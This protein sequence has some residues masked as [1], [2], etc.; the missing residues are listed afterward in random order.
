MRKYLVQYFDGKKSKEKWK[1]YR[2]INE[3]CIEEDKIMSLRKNIKWILIE[4]RKTW[5]LLLKNINP[6]WN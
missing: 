6:E 5:R 1:E 3:A 4:S 2:N